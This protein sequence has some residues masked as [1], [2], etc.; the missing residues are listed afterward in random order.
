[1]QKGAIVNSTVDTLKN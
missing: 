1:M